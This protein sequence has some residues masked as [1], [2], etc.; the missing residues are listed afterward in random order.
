M[1]A[2]NS[3]SAPQTSPAGPVLV[4]RAGA[5]G[6]TLMITPL[7]RQ[8]HQADPR[9]EID[10][11]CSR[12]GAAILA[13][14]RYVTKIHTLELR[15]V[16]YF[17]SPEK[18]RLVHAIRERNYAFAVVLESAKSY[19]EIVEKAGIR[20]VRGFAET[21]FDPT[22]HSIV[23][24]LRAAGFSGCSG[25]DLDMDLPVSPSSRTWAAEALFG[26][27]E[28]WIGIHAGYGPASKKRNQAE[29]LRGWTPANFEQVAKELIAQGA[30]IVLT[31]SAGDRENCE[32]IARAVPADRVL[33]FA[34]QTR[35]DQ[36]VAIVAALDLLISVD[37][38]PAHIAAAAGTP[39]VVLWGPGI[40]RQTRPLSTTTP[41]RILNAN[42]PCAPCY[43][44]PLMKTCRNNICM[45]QIRPA[46]ALAAAG[47]LLNRAQRSA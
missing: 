23:N 3:S 41:I 43:G 8:L 12:G 27:P 36:L 22:R 7:L 31:G 15:N 4:V 10:V 32:A 21:P 37:S 39:L 2:S 38:G 29:R 6:D 13:T 45:Q 5:L 1:N 35:I 44:T 20:D 33:N 47:E 16:P 24:N 40:L 42:V 46:E 9:R 17:W 11:L 18:R 34:G 25:A 30:S 14:S 19:R 28:P 26:L